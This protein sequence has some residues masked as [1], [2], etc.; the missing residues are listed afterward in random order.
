MHRLVGWEVSDFHGKSQEAGDEEVFAA[1]AKGG[2][3]IL[4]GGGEAWKVCGCRAT[5]SDSE[6]RSLRVGNDEVGV[7]LGLSYGFPKKNI[8]VHTI[9][10]F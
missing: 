6:E 3:G 5:V 7:F 1:P 10:K 4:A 8:M 9:S 2:D